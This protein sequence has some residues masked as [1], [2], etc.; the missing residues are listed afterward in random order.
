VDH[1][2]GPCRGWSILDEMN[3]LTARGV[4]RADGR[5]ILFRHRS[6]TDKRL[7]Q[8]TADQLKVAVTGG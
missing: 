7:I 4:G 8:R 1:E 6:A 5:V 3:T 2:Y